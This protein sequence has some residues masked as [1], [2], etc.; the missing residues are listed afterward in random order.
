MEPTKRTISEL[1][2][3]TIQRAFQEA[4]AVRAHAYTPYSGFKVGAALVYDEGQRIQAGCNVENASFGATVCAERNAVLAAIALSGCDRF[5]ALVVVA[6]TEEATPPCA[7]CLQVLSEF[8][9]PDMP[10]YLGDLSG[11]IEQYL[12]ADL[13]PHPFNGASLARHR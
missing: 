11:N 2:D 9:S 5:E 10:V 13:L 6:D 7:L 3:P 1:E 12:F 8:C 4:L